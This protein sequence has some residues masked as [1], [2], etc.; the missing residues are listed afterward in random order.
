MAKTDYIKVVKFGGSSL[1]DGAQFAKVASIVKAEPYRRYVIPSA[2]GRRND[3]D[4]KVTDLLYACCNQAAAGQDFSDTFAKIKDRFNTI[5]S[6]LSL[7]VSLDGEFAKI[8]N[9]LSGDA[10]SADYVASRGEYLNGILLA[11][12][13]GFD[14]VDA[15]DVIFIKENGQY[16]V[17]KTNEVMT[18][19]LESHPFAVIPGFYGRGADGRVKTFSRGGSDITGSIVARAV[20]ASIYENWTDVSGF[21][22]ADPHI[23]ANPKVIE[24]VTYSEL[25]ELSYMGATVLHEEAVFPVRAADI[26][27]NIRNTNRPD[28]R[29][30]MIVLRASL[31]HKCDGITGI[32]GRKGFSVINIEKDLMNSEIGF[33]KKV[34]DVLEQYGV[35]FEH[36]P[37]GIDTL[38]IVVSSALLNAHRQ[39]IIDGIRAAVNPDSLYI[40]DG[41]SLVAVVGRG[42]VRNIG[43]AARII[44]AVASADVNIRMM[45]QGTRENNIILSVEEAD[46]DKTVRVIYNE[47]AG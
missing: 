9:H 25:R 27:I 23:V 8:E 33:G 40:E 15:A 19:V 11:A 34:L 5:I 6:D 43:T 45:D 1:A 42:M 37:S 31:D 18:S 10:P 14:F 21:L 24:T 32:A 44:S 3:H 17:E 41:L 13:L 28:D 12:Y 2:P 30:T 26:P 29:G 4:D 39:E 20:Q 35:S 7:N 16:D 46:F 22:M 38:G 36:I 47:F